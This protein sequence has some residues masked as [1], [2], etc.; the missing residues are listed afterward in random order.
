VQR[1]LAKRMT[2]DL[3]LA[4][5]VTPIAAASWVEAAPQF[6]PGLAGVAGRVG[7]RI[8]AVFPGTMLATNTTPAA[9]MRAVVGAL[10]LSPAPLDE[11]RTRSGFTLL[12]FRTVQLA[13][14]RAGEPPV[15]LHRGGSVHS[16]DDVSPAKLERFAQ[17]LAANLLARSTR[18]QTP[19]NVAK[20]ERSLW[21]HE[22]IEPWKNDV[23]DGLLAS[24]ESHAL[25][26]V[27]LARFAAVETGERRAALTS[28]ARDALAA[29]FPV[30]GRADALRVPSSEVASLGALALDALRIADPNLSV[31][32][33]NIDAMFARAAE[34]AAPGA[35]KRN[36]LSRR[37]LR[38]AGASAVARR[39][40]RAWI[41][42]CPGANVRE[43]PNAEDIA[44]ADSAIREVL[45]AAATAGDLT[46]AMPWL[47]LAIEA[48]HD[49]D[50]SIAAAPALREHRDVVAAHQLSRVDTGFDDRD[51]A[52]G[53][54]FTR[55]GAALPTWRTSQAIVF[56]AVMLGDPRL[57]EDAELPARLLEVLRSL[58]FL[59]QLVAD[60]DVMHMFPENKQALGGVRSALWDQRMPL[61][62]TAMTLLA[63]TETIASLRRR[64]PA[65]PARDAAEPD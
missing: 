14:P 16:I 11:L 2:I 51:L 37:A 34:G 65:N 39:D 49:A 63:V 50:Q 45:S 15:F 7:D 52:G 9:A 40:F 13:Q 38:A 22:D 59:L 30:K 43:E 4:G 47:G 1:D 41:A 60:D 57:T 24:S 6:S 18:M 53:V 48:R 64:L 28:A 32:T 3:Q 36:D 5:P 8:D 31:K 35:E 55:G 21:F 44:R 42:Q 27:A 56:P 33:I 62:A 10:K 23:H 20:A 17:S 29:L 61:E 25:T 58:R 54:I 26:A 46:P 12:R 19:A